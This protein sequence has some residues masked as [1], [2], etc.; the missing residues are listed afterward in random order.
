VREPRED[1]SKTSTSATS[2][3][4]VAAA[5]TPMPIAL[6][7]TPTPIALPIAPTPQAALAPG[8]ASD[9]RETTPVP[10]PPVTAPA[11]RDVTLPAPP[12]PTQ[13]TA[14]AADSS[15]ST[16]PVTRVPVA[17]SS[18]PVAAAPGVGAD[19]TAQ[20]EVA[21]TIVAPVAEMRPRPMPTRGLEAFR[22]FEGP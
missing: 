9:A 8:A 5:I 4:A 11:S 6:P 10:T 17:D 3:L 1:D 20:A 15:P 7:I 21:T 14:T 18:A 2:S 12:A 16:E 19:A 13:P 22:R